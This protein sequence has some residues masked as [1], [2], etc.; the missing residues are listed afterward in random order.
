MLTLKLNKI[1]DIIESKLTTNPF[2]YTYG[3][4]RSII[5]L[6]TFSVFVFNDIDYL[7][8]KDAL[9]VISKSS[10]LFNQ[11]N[12]FGILG[13]ENLIWAKIIV[14]IVLLGVI[15]GFIPKLTGIL[16]FWVV[17]SFHSSALLLDGGDQ[18]A[19]IFTFLLIPI[20]ILDRRIN[21]WKSV[22]TQSTIS[23]LIG[24]LSFL[25]ISIQTSFIYLNTAVEKIYQLDDWKNG[26]ALYYIFN[27]S[28]FGV[29]DTLLNYLGFIINSKMVFFLTWGVI[30]SHL[31]L[32]YSLF[33][34]RNDRKK[35]FWIGV[36][37]HLS[38]ALFMGL[39]SFSFA[40]I[41]VL[42]LYCLPFNYKNDEKK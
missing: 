38:I 34:K 42:I 32:S 39:F 26:T 41:G 4:G 17:Y 15:S 7:F 29:N 24:H 20:T 33:L 12:L 27:N 6:S 25:M 14:L 8:D 10:F 22:K 31:I 23:K 5:A 21:H 11:I 28:F 40:I 9:N 18:I 2:G 36:S 35:V 19:T 30:L 37:L 3:L 13:F 16:H 1:A